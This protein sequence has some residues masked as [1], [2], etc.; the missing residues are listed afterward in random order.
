MTHEEKLKEI[1]EIIDTLKVYIQQD[2]GEFEFI[3][4]END[5]V[6]IKL[7]GACVG[8][9]MVDVTYENGLQ[10]LLRDEVDKNISVQVII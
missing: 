10:E 7:K 9:G 4:Y 1:L 2:G 8:C 6:T 5:I 3:S